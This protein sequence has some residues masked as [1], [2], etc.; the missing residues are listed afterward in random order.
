MKIHDITAPIFEGMTVY[1]NKPEKQPQFSRTTN[2]HV[3]ES[4]ITLDVHTGT[5][6]DAPLHMINEGATFESIPLEK[7]VGPVKVFDL[8]TVEDGITITDLQH[9]DIQENDFILF[10][11]RNS[12]E[13]EFNYEFIFLKEDGA[14]YLAKRNIRG[15]GIDAL[16]VERSQPGHPTHKALFDANIIVIE[17]LRLKNVPAD[18]YFM[19]AAPLKLVGTDA[20]P[21]RVLLFKDI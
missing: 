13:D 9:L 19:V 20:S 17:G 4:R 2:A 15:V 7:L 12:F 14:H 5:H 6:I 18:Q 3:T 8:T 21:A 1:K 11:T 10:K 16:G